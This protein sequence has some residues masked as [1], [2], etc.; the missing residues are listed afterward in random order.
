MARKAKRQYKLLGSHTFG[1]GNRANRGDVVELEVELAN[2]PLFANKLE[3]VN[4]PKE[5]K[6]PK[7][8]NPNEGEGEAEDKPN[9]GEGETEPQI[10]LSCVMV[11]RTATAEL[12][13][14]EVRFHLH[15][16]WVCPQPRLHLH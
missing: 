8:P 13:S 15:P 10:S 16:H 5:P 11:P 7:E 12:K 4:E 9:E 1:D 2:S 6:E 14:F 3:A